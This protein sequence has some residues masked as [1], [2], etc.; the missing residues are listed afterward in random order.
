MG[1]HRD[2]ASVRFARARA[3][4]TLVE[5]LVVI[6]V[7]GLLIAMMLAG[8]Q[9][10]REA[11]RRAGCSN[12]LHQV[13][14]GMLSHHSAVSTFPA[15][16]VEPIS[17][18]WPKGRQLAWSAYL[19]PY[20]DEQTLYAR[21]NLNKGFNSPENSLPAAQVVSIYICPSAPH[22]TLLRSSRGAC[23]YG[24]IYGERIISPNNPPKG[25]MIYDQAIST[26][27]ITDG[28]SHTMLVSEDSFSDDGQWINGLNLFDVSCAV[29]KA[30]ENDIRSRHPGGACGLFADG[31]VRFLTEKMNLKVLAAICTRAGGELDCDW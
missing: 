2:W 15:G 3:G 19:L 8:V 16:C 5:L 9:A 22:P 12:N 1:S 28:T 7:I 13:A 20:I 31:S 29:N 11:A 14:L 17:K 4:F 30:A 10:A 18:K 23:D 26:R 25:T 21:L 27:Q 24:G 6:T